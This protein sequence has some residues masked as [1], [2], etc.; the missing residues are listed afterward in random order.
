MLERIG[1]VEERSILWNCSQVDKVEI[2]HL[3][4]KDHRGTPVYSAARPGTEPD[5]AAA[6]ESRGFVREWRA[7]VS[8][9]LLPLRCCEAE[10]GWPSELGRRLRAVGAWL[11]RLCL[12]GAPTG[13][14]SLAVP[15]EPPCRTELCA[16]PRATD[17]GRLGRRPPGDALVIST[18]LPL[19][20]RL[21][22]LQRKLLLCSG[23][24]SSSSWPRLAGAPQLVRLRRGTRPEEFRTHPTRVHAVDTQLEQVRQC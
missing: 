7:P 1:A 24:L 2:P 23:G 4:V 14:T 13:V 9:G 12:A 20:R 3:P 11:C 16:A 22:L 17:V 6:A 8:D 10:A 15:L 5:L 21:S 18:P 19:A